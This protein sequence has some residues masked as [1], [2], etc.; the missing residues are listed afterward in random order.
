MTLPFPPS[1][2]LTS[3]TALIAFLAILSCQGAPPPPSSTPVPAIPTPAAVVPSPTPT[4]VN[5]TPTVI[6][7]ATPNPP[8]TT[9]VPPTPVST[10]VP[11]LIPTVAP[12]LIP[13]V[14][15]SQPAPADK[16]IGGTP[17]YLDDRSDSAAVIRSF[18]NALDRKEYDRAYSYWEN[19]AASQQLLPYPQFKQGYAATGLIQVTIGG[20]TG[21]VGAGQTYNSVP[22]AL[23]ATLTD[24]S[25]QL[26]TGCYVLH[27]ANPQIQDFPP[28]HPWAIQRAHLELA[29]PGANPVDLL[30]GACSAAS[31][32]AGIPVPTQTPTSATDISAARYL[33]DRS[34]PEEVLRSLFNAVNRKE[35]DR[36]YSYWE[37]NLT[38]T[39]LPS[40]AQFKQGYASTASVELTFGLAGSG[41]AA[42]NIYFTIPTLLVAH[43]TDG[44][45]QSFVGCYTLQLGQPAIQDQPPF[46]PVAIGLAQVQPFVAGS[47][48]SSALAYA[49]PAVG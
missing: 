15:P 20:I 48:P 30:P 37:T 46:Q 24:N 7:T 12:T 29:P 31:D 9:P 10:I 36:A 26:Y 45:T 2:L 38:S 23:T 49:C 16:T 22:V 41:V 8:T 33:D 18:Y 11:T 4:A 34:T 35:Y 19:G 14:A 44:Q 27:L 25:N 32:G 21:G 28:F 17:P 47:N 6:P 5:A 42:G 39:Q 13:T 40:Y 3:L 43:T 1:R